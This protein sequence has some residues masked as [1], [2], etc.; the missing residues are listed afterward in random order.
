MMTMQGLV[1]KTQTCRARDR[2][3]TIWQQP[4][5]V[6]NFN[7]PDLFQVLL[8]DDGSLWENDY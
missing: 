6:T 5:W 7:F 4:S 2:S 8:E 1:N 3:A